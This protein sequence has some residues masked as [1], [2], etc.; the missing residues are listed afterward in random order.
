[1]FLQFSIIFANVHLFFEKS[2]KIFTAGV[3]GRQKVP[4]RGARVFSCERVATGLWVLGEEFLRSG[5][6]G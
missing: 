2:R 6:P 4:R 3:L 5:E 1:M